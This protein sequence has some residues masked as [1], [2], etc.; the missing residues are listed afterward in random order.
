MDYTQEPQQPQVAFTPQ[1]LLDIVCY[2]REQRISIAERVEGEGRGG[3]LIDEGTIKKVLFE[4]DIFK[5]HIIDETARKFSDIIVLDYDKITRHPVNIK[6]SV[7]STDNCF[8]KIG[9]VYALTDI[10]DCDLPKSMNFMQMVHLIKTHKSDLAH[11]DYWYLC[12]DKKDSTNVLIRGMKQINCW[13]VNI[14]PSNT[15]QVNW[16]KEKT[17]PPK[18]R[19]YEEVYE[20][21]FTSIKKSLQGFWNSIPNELKPTL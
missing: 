11:R 2:L 5:E 6:T 20:F 16:T 17:M 9:L 14:N 19:T 7:G 18:Y 1:I 10:S 4:H 21:F 15:L 12:V 8:S 3:S 13:V